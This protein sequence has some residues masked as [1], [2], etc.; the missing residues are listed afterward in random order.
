MARNTMDK[1]PAHWN[2]YRRI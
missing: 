2:H 1:A